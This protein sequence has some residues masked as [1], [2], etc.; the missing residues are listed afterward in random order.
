M[1]CRKKFIF[2]ASIVLI[3]ITIASQAQNWPQWRGKNFHGVAEKGEYPVKIS[4]PNDVLWEAELPGKG[5]S[6]PIIWKGKIILTSGV[7]EGEEGQDGVLCYDWTGKKLWQVELGTQSP[8]R[9]KRG[10]GSNSSAITDG[11]RIFVLFKS[12]TLAALDFDGNILW[13]TNLIDSFGELTFWWDF[14]TSPVLAE[15]NVVVA[16]QH[17]GDSYLVA[18]EQASGDL[19]W[20]ADRTYECNRE[21][22]QSYTTPLVV[23][24]GN[25]TE[26]VVWG[27]DHLTG[28]DAST[29]Q[30]RWSYSGFNPENKQ[31]W[32]TI[33]SP[34]ISDGIAVVP[35]GRGR[36]LAGMK[37]GGEGE[38]TDNDWLWGKTGIGTD[39]A[40][41]VVTDGKVYILDFGG[42]LWCL[43]IHTGEELWGTKLPDVRGVFYS[44]PTLAGKNLYACSDDGSF[45]VCELK[46]DGILV[47]THFS[48]DDNFVASPVLLKNKLLLRGTKKL[49]CFGK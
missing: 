31:F 3:L 41:P 35:Y 20:K 6:T 39:V 13:K 17:E 28:H 47:Q 29:G 9:H 18:H 1:I 48:F 21:T 43:D 42:K 15:G 34:V 36:F 8:G 12:T 4:S 49:Y 19:A 44:S 26:I 5:G 7:G 11:K 38:M 40:T 23:N 27:A 45:Y 14:G 22:A 37:T 33:A 32:R 30:L 25:K 24:D 46:E 16:V 2:A 10:T